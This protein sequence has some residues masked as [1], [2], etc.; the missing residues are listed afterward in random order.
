[1]SII[2]LFLLPNFDEFLL[3]NTFDLICIFFINTNQIFQLVIFF[4]FY[5][6]HSN[7]GLKHKAWQIILE[8]LFYLTQ[9]NSVPVLI[10]PIN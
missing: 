10:I 1:M 3:T 2:F 9:L 7:A 5:I 4:Y 6:L 8:L